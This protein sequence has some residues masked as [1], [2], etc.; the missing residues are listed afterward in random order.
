MRVDAVVAAAEARLLEPAGGRDVALA[1]EFT[2]TVFPA[3]RARA[4]RRARLTFAV[5]IEAARAYSVA[6]A[7]A[8]ASSK[9]STVRT[10]RTGPKI[11]SLACFSVAGDV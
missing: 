7:S 5:K 6:F 8:M 3:R 11:S 10:D 4:P 1:E 2:V 9:L